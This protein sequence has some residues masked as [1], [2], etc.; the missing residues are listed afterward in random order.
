MMWIGVAAI[1]EKDYG[2]WQS[3]TWT[4]VHHARGD[5]V[6]DLAN[7]LAARSSGSAG[8]RGPASSATTARGSTGR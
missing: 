6:R 8:A 2:I 7:G 1:R 4:E 3:Y 5:N